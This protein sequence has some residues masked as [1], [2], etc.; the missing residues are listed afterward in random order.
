M[1][2]ISKNV[3]KKT[4]ICFSAFLV[5]NFFLSLIS[6]ATFAAS[7]TYEYDNLNRLT[8]ASYA[9]GRSINYTYDATGNILSIDVT[10]GPECPECSASPVTLTNVTFSS[11][12]NCECR[13]D[14]SITIGTGVFIEAGANI[15]FKAPKIYIQSGAKLAKGANV[16]LKQN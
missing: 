7:V 14:I 5:F 15:T 10:L 1:G 2:T 4:S 9:T 16:E 12:R 8:K 6:A 11:G 13:D 3:I